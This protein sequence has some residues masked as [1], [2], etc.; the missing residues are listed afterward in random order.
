LAP[1]NGDPFIFYQ[2]AY[3]RLFGIR[4]VILCCGYLADKIYDR[5]GN[6]YGDIEIIYSKE[7][8]PLGTGG[9]LVNAYNHFDHSDE[10][11]VMNGDTYCP[12]DF[13]SFYSFYK[14]FRNIVCAIT[15]VQNPVKNRYGSI[16]INEDRISHFGEKELTWINAGMYIISTGILEPYDQNTKIL[17]LEKRFS[18]WAKLNSLYGYKASAYI[19]FIVI[20][21]PESYQEAQDLL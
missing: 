8:R 21:T 18:I 1:I 3:L 2:L 12:I 7:D 14:K 5:V 13:D 19:K 15:L 9:A 17:S 20:G 4:K 10:I 16:K 6:N 11:L